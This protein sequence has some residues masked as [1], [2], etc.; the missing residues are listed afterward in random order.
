VTVSGNQ[1]SPGY[2]AAVDTTGGLLSASR[3]LPPRP[4]PTSATAARPWPRETFDQSEVIR[5]A[6]NP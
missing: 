1:G 4:A 2:W 6:R 5:P 3:L